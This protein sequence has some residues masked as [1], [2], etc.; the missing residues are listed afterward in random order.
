MTTR[1]SHCVFLLI[2]VW[3]LTDSP[4]Q[5]PFFHQFINKSNKIKRKLPALHSVYIYVY[6]APEGVSSAPLLLVQLNSLSLYCSVTLAMAH[7]QNRDGNAILR[8]G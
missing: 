8:N 2:F 3:T 5:A 1:V 6:T 4:F 7:F